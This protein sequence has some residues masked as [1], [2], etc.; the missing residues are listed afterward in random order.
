M[1]EHL[2]KTSQQQNL[3]MGKLIGYKHLSIGGSYEPSFTLWRQ[4]YSAFSSPADSERVVSDSPLG[5]PPE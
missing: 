5:R 4:K 3:R 1:R 2:S